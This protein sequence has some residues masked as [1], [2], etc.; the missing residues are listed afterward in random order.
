MSPDFNP[1]AAF[2]QVIQ[3]L[4]SLDA[5]QKVVQ[6]VLVQTMDIQTNML[7]TQNQMLETQNQMLETQNQMQLDIRQ[8]QGSQ[9]DLLRV[10]NRML[11]YMKFAFDQQAKWN[12]R[13]DQFNIVVLDELREIKLDLREIKK[14]V[15][16]E[17]ETRL[18]KLEDF[19]NDQ[20]RKAS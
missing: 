18:I 12:E 19:M 8:L 20:L 11:D 1:Q 7:Q 16:G 15:F 6:Q 14:K 4:D 17:V 3:R 5:S 10:Q 9:L 13:Q 2:E